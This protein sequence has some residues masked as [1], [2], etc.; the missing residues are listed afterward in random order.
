MR[1]GNDSRGSHLHPPMSTLY[2]R[3]VKRAFD[4]ITSSILLAV[5]SPVLLAV[6]AVV[7][8]IEGRPVFFRQVRP[9]RNE[10]PFGMIKFRTMRDALGPRG[11]QLPDEQRI[12]RLGAFLRRTSLDELPELLNVLGGSMSLVGPRPLLTRYLPYYRAEERKRFR[13]RPGITGL[14]QVHGRNLLSWND[15]LALD[16]RYHDQISFGLDLRILLSTV[17]AVFFARGVVVVAERVMANLDDERRNELSGSC[18]A[19]NK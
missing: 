6:A 12:T 3:Y 4:V 2:A 8:G 11:D 1:K 17:R 19:K 9:G 10:R 5:L 13:L 16:V 18:G 7:L 14:A 15:R